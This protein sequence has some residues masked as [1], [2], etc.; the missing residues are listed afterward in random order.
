ML[1]FVQDAAE[2][3]GQGQDTLWHT[4]A[5]FPRSVERVSPSPSPLLLPGQALHSNCVLAS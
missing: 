1:Q 3:R 5:I 2:G 4:T